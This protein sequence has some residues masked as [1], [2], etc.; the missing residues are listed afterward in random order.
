MGGDGG[1]SALVMAAADTDT[2]ADTDACTD[3]AI[4]TDTVTHFESEGI[5]AKFTCRHIYINTF[6][7]LDSQSRIRFTR[8]HENPS[9]IPSPEIPSLSSL[10]ALL[11]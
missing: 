6:T 11:G 1:G 2:D 9:Q 4:D 3:T 10:V 8:I 7:F 5:G